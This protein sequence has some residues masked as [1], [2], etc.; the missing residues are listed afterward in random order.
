[1]KKLCIIICIAALLSTQFIFANA[2]DTFSYDIIM[3]Y[4]D[5]LLTFKGKTTPNDML[6]IEVVPANEN[7]ANLWSSIRNSKKTKI[8]EEVTV[9]Y[10]ADA[11]TFADFFE[12]DSKG[13]FSLTASIT[14]YNEYKVLIYSEK[15]DCIV[16][17]NFIFTDKDSYK[18]VVDIL[19][20]Y[21][22]SND[23]SSFQRDLKSINTAIGF[24]DSDFSALNFDDIS[25][26]IFDELVLTNSD[27]STN[28]SSDNEKIYHTAGLIVALNSGM[29]IEGVSDKTVVS[30]ATDS[31]FDSFVNRI[32]VTNDSKNMFASLMLNKNIADF[33]DFSDK[34]KEALILTAVKYPDGTTNIQDLFN[35]YGTSVLGLSSVSTNSGVYDKLAGNTYN[36]INELVTAYNGFV[37]TL[38]NGGNIIVNSG[39]GWGTGGGGGGGS[40]VGT[41]GVVGIPSSIAGGSTGSAPM[42]ETLQM[43]FEDLNSVPWAYSAISNLYTKKII[44][45]V[46]ENKFMP[47]KNVKREEFVKMLI[48]ATELPV[49][50]VGNEFSDVEKGSWYEAYIKT[51]HTNKLVSGM[52]DN[53]FGVGANISR[54]D[55]AVMV[56][57]AM[58]K[59]G[60]TPKGA[61]L[62]FEDAGQVSDYAKTAVAELA[63]L[64]IVTGVDSVTFNPTGVA[65]RAQAAVIINRA[66]S[67]LD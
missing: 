56:M 58:I 51:A 3:N 10:N 60:Y 6:S 47:D 63:G 53:T 9:A 44:N 48:S 28:N 43:P 12:A 40:S 29:L 4:T 64:G 27:L 52:P 20:G 49:S 14:E 8:S 31:K 35:E 18:G 1:M 19:N 23:K 57:N 59:C 42:L 13:E 45:G 36:T 26:L 65:T 24:S 66:L 39:S 37:A 2:A 17:K 38:G 61:T 32:F 7:L 34:A 22:G 21:I 30:N 67:Y 33:E 41:S 54:Q 25:D 15:N 62:T 16:E 55:M 46:S 50:D 11:V 5:N